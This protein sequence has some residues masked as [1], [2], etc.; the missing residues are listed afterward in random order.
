M[1][2]NN[3][4]NTLEFQIAFG[5]VRHFGR[6]LYTTNPP[7]I[8]ELVANAWDAY[9]RKCDLCYTSNSLLIVDNGIG[10]NDEEFQKRYATSGKPRQCFQASQ[11]LRYIRHPTFTRT[12]PPAKPCSGAAFSQRTACFCSRNCIQRRN[13]TCPK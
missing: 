7:A 4:L 2:T 5:A 1:S 13:C 8:A 6:N 12:L 3:L 10:M 9:A 11:T